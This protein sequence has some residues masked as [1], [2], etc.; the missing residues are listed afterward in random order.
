MQR[1]V[2]YALFG[3]TL[4][5]ILA[6]ACATTSP[7]QAAPESA[8]DASYLSKPTAEEVDM[9]GRADPLTQATFWNEYYN[10]FPK[11][12]D[13]ALSF[14]KALRQINSHDRVIEVGRNS[15]LLFAND[16]D[17][18]LELGR[19]YGALNMGAEALQAYRNSAAAAPFDPAPHAA[20][21]VLYD[22]IGQH[23]E[24][25]FAYRQA[26]SLDPNR[27]VTLSNYGLSLALT[28]NL[29][30]AE[31][32]LRQAISLPGSNTS[33]RQNFALILSLLGKFEEAQSIAALDAPGG[34]AQKNAEFLK[35]LIGNNPQFSQFVN[36]GDISK[37]APARVGTRGPLTA[38]DDEAKASPP[39][40]LRKR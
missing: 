6:G 7:P 10:S 21:A 22:N 1:P 38:N 5:L 11:D 30:D 3:S 13:I 4:F 32:A 26:L 39:F 25:Q 9:I 34:V 24:A 27:A 16:A 8:L 15:Q 23:A 33:I 36:S 31:T 37:P 40:E 35:E 12:R 20:L 29:E 28:G 18:W 2:F 14:M 19:S 17:I